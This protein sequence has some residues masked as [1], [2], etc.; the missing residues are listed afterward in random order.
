MKFHHPFFCRTPAAPLSQ[1][2]T[3]FR[4]VATARKTPLFQGRC[5]LL[6]SGLLISSYL[7]KLRYNLIIS[8][9]GCG[10]RRSRSARRYSPMGG[11]GTEYEE[12][13]EDLDKAE[14]GCKDNE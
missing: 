13:G 4:Q 14:E 2:S 10:V 3:H 8:K 12:G 9:L 7:S 11:N 5:L 1:C 6:D